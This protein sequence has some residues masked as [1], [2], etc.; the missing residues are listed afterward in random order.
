MMKKYIYKVNF[1]IE[2]DPKDLAKQEK[3]DEYIDTLVKT[4]DSLQV[5]SQEIIDLSN[6]SNCGQCVKCHTWA[7]DKRLDN[8]IS[9]LSNGAIVNKDWLCDLCLP[10]NHPNAF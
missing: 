4:D 10:K 2:A 5:V 1:L 3:I 9:E 6:N 7:T 8:S